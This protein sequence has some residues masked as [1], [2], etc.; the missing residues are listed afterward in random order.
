MKPNP[1]LLQSYETCDDPFWKFVLE[2]L[3]YGYFPA[4]IRVEDDILYYP[5]KKQYTLSPETLVDDIQ[6]LFKTE[7]FNYYTL[8]VITVQDWKQLK[9]K[10][11]RKMFLQNFMIHLHSLHN[12][13]YSKLSVLLHFLIIMID[14]KIIKAEDIITEGSHISS[15][16]GLKTKS[17][18]ITVHFKWDSPSPPSIQEEGRS[19]FK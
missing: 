2:K 12:I 4:N 17:G 9:K 13:P 10:R 3:M 5:D 8:P 1:L 19:I 6:S 7:I 15:I 14:F 11:T 18:S 16:N